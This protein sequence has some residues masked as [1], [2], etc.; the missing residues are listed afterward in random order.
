MNHSI[1][2]T[3]A[4]AFCAAIVCCSMTIAA[5][6][7]EVTSE[8]ASLPNVSVIDAHG[9]PVSLA[10]LKG[11]V[12]LLDFIHIGCP[13]V[14]ATLVSKFGEVADSLKPELGS[15]VV[16]LSVTNDPE[17][18]RPEQLLALA[19]SSDADLDGWLFVTG[20]PT[21]VDRVIQAFGVNNE[22][23]PDGSPAHITQVF[24]LGTDGQKKREYRGML[25]KPQAVVSQI[26][27][28]MTQV[29]GGAS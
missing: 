29:Q 8:P 4:S 14:C 6:H 12:I 22:K 25:M 21:D 20:K 13:G 11:K 27:E 15:K 16:L 5:C 7:R 18:D 10:S 9:R 3:W 24:L 28:A 2:S 1:K 23:M 19:R 26:R 17:H